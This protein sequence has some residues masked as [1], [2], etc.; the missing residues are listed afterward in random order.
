MVLRLPDSWSNW[1]LEVFVFEERGEPEYLE[2]NLSKQRREPTTNST[3]IWRRRCEL[4]PGHIKG[5][6]LIYHCACATLTPFFFSVK[7][8]Q[9]NRT[10]YELNSLSATEKFEIWSWQS[11]APRR[12]R[13][14]HSWTLPWV[15]TSLGDTAR[16]LP[17]FAR[18]MDQ[19]TTPRH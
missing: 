13:L 10:Y 4:N 12:F 14:D 19:A 3:H 15:V 17:D 2:R 5:R 8:S 16:S 1:N 6:R 18:T 9:F 11:L 7:L